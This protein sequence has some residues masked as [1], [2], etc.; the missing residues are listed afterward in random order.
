MGFSAW[1]Q[2]CTGPEECGQ[3]LDPTPAWANV[4]AAIVPTHLEIWADYCI[5]H[6]HAGS[7][8]V[9]AVQRTDSTLCRQYSSQD[10][11]R[12][13]TFRGRAMHEVYLYDD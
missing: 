1:P 13:F 11:G 3:G 8:R 7:D 4:S 6:R 9:R 10:G 5:G 2:A 12:M